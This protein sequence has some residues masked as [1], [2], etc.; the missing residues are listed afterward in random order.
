MPTS[1][2][3]NPFEVACVVNPIYH[4][5]LLLCN[6]LHLCTICKRQAKAHL[7]DNQS[8]HN[9]PSTLKTALLRA[10]TQSHQGTGRGEWQWVWSREGK[11]G[12]VGGEERLFVLLHRM[13]EVERTCLLRACVNQQ[14]AGPR[15]DR[16]TDREGERGCP[17]RVMEHA[18]Q[19]M[20]RDGVCCPFS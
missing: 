15:E 5:T 17:G 7:W 8:T 16:E 14:L 12:R 9:L 2:E 20:A 1:L 4:S 3:N 18:K 19:Q 13:R 10:I 6:Q 11:R